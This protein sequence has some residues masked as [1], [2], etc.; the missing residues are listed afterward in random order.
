MGQKLAHLP[1]TIKKKAEDAKTGPQLSDEW[2]AMHD[3]FKE[4]F[5]GQTGR[6][7][8]NQLREGLCHYPI[9]QPEGPVRYCGL[10]ADGRYCPEHA[11]RCGDGYE[12]RI[13][14]NRHFPGRYVA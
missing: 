6:L 1:T 12:R 2:A 9:D 5:R 11:R 14:T 10:H 8:I 3:R 4:G 13:T 7:A